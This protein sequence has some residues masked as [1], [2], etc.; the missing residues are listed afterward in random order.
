MV[1]GWGS[2]AWCAR[3]KLNEMRE[4][5]D[6]LRGVRR[7]LC[8]GV[9]V[10]APVSRKLLNSMNLTSPTQPHKLPG[11]GGSLQIESQVWFGCRELRP[12]CTARSESD[13]QDPGWQQIRHIFKGFRNHCAPRAGNSVQIVIAQFW[14]GPVS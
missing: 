7:T 5:T 13:W 11:G 1:A 14:G 3:R 10:C 9:A 8:D 12:I 6:C 2:G 4:M